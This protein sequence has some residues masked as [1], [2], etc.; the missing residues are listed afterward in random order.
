[1]K[2]RILRQIKRCKGFVSQ[3]GKRKKNDHFLITILGLRL[4]ECQNEEIARRV[5]GVA[6]KLLSR[7]LVTGQCERNDSDAGQMH[8]VQISSRYLSSNQSFSMR[9]IWNA[10]VFSA[11]IPSSRKCC[12]I[13]IFLIYVTSEIYSVWRG[14]FSSIYMEISFLLTG[15]YIP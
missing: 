14:I 2:W 9:L 10:I 3:I 11:F 8:P 13:V 12:I 5:I 15:D 4:S 7:Q 6:R 1:M